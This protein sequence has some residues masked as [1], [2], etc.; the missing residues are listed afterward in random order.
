MKH[1][2]L[3]NATSVAID[4]ENLHTTLEKTCQVL[5]IRRPIAVRFVDS[6]EMIHLN[7]GFRA[8]PE[9]TDVLTFPSGLD[10]P[11]PLGDIAI[12]VPYAIDQAKLRH[13]DLTNELTALMVHGCLHLIGYDDLTDK[14]RTEMQ[15][16][17]NEVGERIGIPID[18][19]WTSILHQ[20]NE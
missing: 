11:L 1:S 4:L 20:D 3:Q 14:D 19:E 2:P 7:T 15:R 17:M 18:G 10:D 6:D 16:K 12:C 8:V 5:N 13:V 9:D